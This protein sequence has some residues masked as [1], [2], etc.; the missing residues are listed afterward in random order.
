MNSTTGIPELE[1]EL[2]KPHIF[3]LYLRS[4]Y[5]NIN[6]FEFDI[7]DC[8]EFLKLKDYLQDKNERK[9]LTNLCLQNVNFENFKDLYKYYRPRNKIVIALGLFVMRKCQ[10]LFLRPDHI[11]DLKRPDNFSEKLKNLKRDD[12]EKL[13][14]I[15]K[16]FNPEE[17]FK[18]TQFLKAYIKPDDYMEISDACLENQ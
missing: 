16:V 9:Q 4:L 8:H 7:H 6:Q 5:M 11:P 2:E 12:M 10:V 17:N 18:F 3:A 13:L 14:E 1:M 15:I